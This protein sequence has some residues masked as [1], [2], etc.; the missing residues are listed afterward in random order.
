MSANTV[1]PFATPVIVV[2]VTHAVYI[3]HHAYVAKLNIRQ[4]K[5]FVGN[6]LT[7]V[8]TFSEFYVHCLYGSELC[9][10]DENLLHY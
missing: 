1:E 3:N 10:E 9:Q 6:L 2:L 5:T 8:K 7:R 4:L